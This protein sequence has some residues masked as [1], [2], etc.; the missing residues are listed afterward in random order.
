MPSFTPNYFLL[1]PALTDHIDQTITGMANNFGIIDTTMKAISD[2][3]SSEQE[4]IESINSQLAE[5][6]SQRQNHYYVGATLKY[7]TITEAYNKWVA[8]GKPNGI[9]HIMKGEY[10][11]SIKAFNVEN[12]L[13]FIGESK[14]DVIWHTKKGYY[15]DAPLHVMNAYI[16]GITF[17][18]DSSENPSYTFIPGGITSWTGSEG[19]AYA[20]HC[21]MSGAGSTLI[22]DCD[23]ISYMN[24]GFGSGTRKDQTIELRNVNIYSFLPSGAH[25]E[26]ARNGGMLY[27]T[28]S[29]TEQ[30]GQKLR[31]QNLKIFSENYRAF[32]YEVFSTEENMSEVEIINCNFSSNVV[33][34]EDLV[35]FLLSTGT[36]YVYLSQN[37]YGN[38]VDKCNKS[39]FAK[40]TQASGAAIRYN[41]L[42]NAK[43]GFFMANG[44]EGDLNTPVTEWVVGI[45]VSQDAN[46]FVVQY[47][48]TILG[49][50]QKYRRFCNNG[51]WT[52]WEPCTDNINDYLAVATGGNALTVTNFNDASKCGY[53]LCDNTVG[54]NGTSSS[55]IHFIH[56]ISANSL[57]KIQYAW[58]LLSKR[59]YVRKMINGVWETSWDRVPN[60]YSL[61]TA[62]RNALTG[63]LAGDTVFDYTIGKPVWYSA[64]NTWVDATGAT[65]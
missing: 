60:S 8:D 35:R 3:V 7:K 12:K 62:Q 32:E 59:Q 25:S 21:D 33:T 47:A 41:N 29:A 43:Y 9:I 39:I 40:L 37:S 56:T 50:K 27:H 20:L 11:E 18:A 34:G 42:N 22:E 48:W 38:N 2:N 1:K 31:M 26:I 54:S 6:P 16:K 10:N 30:T 44:T 65:V 63:M 61:T 13:S 64:S 51:T 15:Q 52:S 5:M 36:G 24:C 28:A 4:N 46:N 53:Y 58:P 23:L 45:A 55:G 17:I 19:A 57:Y 49:T 14:K